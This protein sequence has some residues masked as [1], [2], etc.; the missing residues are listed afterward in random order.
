MTHRFETR[1]LLS[2]LALVAVYACGSGTDNNGGGGDP[3]PTGII[4]FS[5]TRLTG[6]PQLFYM[7]AEGTGVTHITTGTVHDRDPVLSPDGQWVAYSVNDTGIAHLFKIQRNG[8]G[9]VQLTD[10]PASDTQPA[11]SPNGQRLVFTRSGVGLYMIDANGAGGHAVTNDLGDR[12]AAWSP[13]GSKIVFTGGSSG[14]TIVDTSGSG[15]ISPGNVNGS[16]PAWSPD[17][18]RILFGGVIQNQEIEVMNIDGS[19]V[20]NLTQT[21]DGEIEPAWSPDGKFII[22]TGFRNGND[23]IVRRRADGSAEKILAPLGAEDRHP[24]WG[25]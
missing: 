22:F 5:S 15:R 17:G 24:S 2:A 9:K 25:P 14:I 16:D 1:E 23:E 13:N 18:T 20:M 6:L 3:K 8:A 11:W 7:N 4:V 12:Q 19:N 21:A 10:D